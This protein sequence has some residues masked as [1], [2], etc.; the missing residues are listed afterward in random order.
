VEAYRLRDGM[1]AISRAELALGL[2]EVDHILAGSATWH[3]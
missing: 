1:G 2:L 3:R